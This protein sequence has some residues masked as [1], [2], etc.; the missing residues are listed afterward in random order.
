MKLLLSV[1]MV[2]II[3][4]SSSE[5]C[6]EISGKLTHLPLPPP[7]SRVHLPQSS[8]VQRASETDGSQ[9]LQ[10]C[11]VPW[12]LDRFGT[13]QTCQHVHQTGASNRFWVQF[14]TSA[15]RLPA[16]HCAAAFIK[17][18]HLRH[19]TNPDSRGDL[20]QTWAP[21]GLAVLQNHE[22]PIRMRTSSHVGTSRLMQQF[23]HAKSRKSYTH[24]GA[25]PPAPVMLVG[26]THFGPV[27]VPPADR[28]PDPPSRV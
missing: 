15:A 21:A 5:H 28:D 23:H 8:R 3:T 22:E 19:N 9:E 24:G 11:L 20:G 14:M 10:V 16:C 26:L 1:Y 25:P 12:R 2:T 6:L 4:K 18:L 17:S 27:L 13:T 7:G